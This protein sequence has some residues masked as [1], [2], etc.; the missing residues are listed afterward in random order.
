ML[1][2]SKKSETGQSSLIVSYY[3]HDNFIC[4]SSKFSFAWQKIA[5]NHF[6]AQAVILS[7]CQANLALL[8]K[9]LPKITLR[10]KLCKIIVE[11][12]LL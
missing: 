4:V 3:F 9:K 1:M 7:V 6:E 11:S 10:L 8:G 5:K 2:S 12:L